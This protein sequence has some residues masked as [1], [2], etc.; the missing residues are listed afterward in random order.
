M[1]LGLIFLEL[2]FC[3]ILILLLGVALK[4]KNGILLI[5]EREIL[6]ILGTDLWIGEV[7]GVRTSLVV[8]VNSENKN[9]NTYDDKINKNNSIQNY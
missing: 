2:T 7:N 1:D 4:W 6:W 3:D 9:N 5:S 8:S